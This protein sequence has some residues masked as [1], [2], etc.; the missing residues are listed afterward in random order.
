[1]RQR[2]RH[3]SASAAHASP[4]AQRTLYKHQRHQQRR[5]RAVARR[6]RE[7]GSRKAR[8][9][10][11]LW[12]ED[13]APRDLRDHPL[14]QNG[15]VKRQKVALPAH[16]GGGGRAV[17]VAQRMELVEA[18]DVDNGV[19]ANLQAHQVLHQRLRT[20]APARRQVAGQLAQAGEEH[21]AEG[22]QAAEQ[23]L[24]AQRAPVERRAVRRKVARAAAQV[25]H[26]GR[27]VGEPQL[28]G[29]ALVV[30]A[31]H[32]RV[33]VDAA[34][35][36]AAA[37]ARRR[38]RLALKQLRK[39]AAV[40]YAARVRVHAEAQAAAAAAAVCSGGRAHRRR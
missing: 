23:L 33:R 12:E 18:A 40:R 17:G 26:H 38:R 19:C 29:N 11:Q 15:G 32:Q 5:E 6:Q 24:Q 27:Q 9:A 13:S 28:H 2:Q 16:G 3:V 31:A 20:G 22:Q 39:A 34:L 1:M 35:R 8:V 7:R 4:Q 25:V 37:Q 10:Q 30:G 36:R 21:E 14:G